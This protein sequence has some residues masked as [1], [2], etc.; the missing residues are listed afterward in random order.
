MT[1]VRLHIAYDG[2]RYHGWQRQPNV[3]TVEGELL[4][5]ISKLL[6]CD[7]DVVQLQGASRTDAGVHARGQ[8]AN[9]VF[10]AERT[11]W[12]FVRGL[13]AMTA[14]DITVNTA[15]VVRDDF[16]SRFDTGGK[17]YIYSIWNHRFS[18]PWH[19]RQQWRL[20]GSFDVGSMKDA[21]KWLIGEL[22]FASFRASDCQAATTV[23]E[24]SRIDILENE[25]D[26]KFVVEGT[27]FL[28]NMVRILVGTL[29]EVGLGQ[30]RA[31][32]LRDVVA[33]RDRTKAG[34]TAP[35]S[36]LCLDE[37][38]YPDDPWSLPADIGS[39]QLA[40]DESVVSDG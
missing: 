2:T 19:Y 23:R 29:V 20:G 17:R 28:K 3:Q 36:G 26:L 9:V 12:D 4:R 39:W 22:D 16:N 8:V 13:N 32:S 25:T 34:R 11:P 40:H 27:A 30:R 18:H 7:Q 10:E 21:T 37:V 33:A 6:D 31:E 14:D 24:I 38:F 15:E 5:A 1:N 35:A